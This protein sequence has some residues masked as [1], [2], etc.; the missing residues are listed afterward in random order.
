MKILCLLGSFLGNLILAINQKADERADNLSA[1]LA[2]HGDYADCD[3]V[4]WRIISGILLCITWVVAIPL[5]L[6]MMG[7]YTSCVT[8]SL[9]GIMIPTFEYISNISTSARLILGVTAPLAMY[10]V[11]FLFHYIRHAGWRLR[12]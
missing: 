8:Y 6:I 7:I 2:L 5:F 12:N 3:S 4:G 10:A 1:V 9:F 11:L